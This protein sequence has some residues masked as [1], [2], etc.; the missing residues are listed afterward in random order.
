MKNEMKMKS[1]GGGSESEASELLSILAKSKSRQNF[2]V[3]GTC[4][5]LNS[6]LLAGYKKGYQ[7]SGNAVS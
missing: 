5:S 3:S 2:E 6:G 4:F 7:Q 1:P